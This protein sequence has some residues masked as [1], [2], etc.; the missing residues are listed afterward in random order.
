VIEMLDVGGTGTIYSV[1][2]AHLAVSP[3]YQ[4][5]LPYSVA[6]V[7][8]DEGPRVLGR[9]VGPGV[10]G[11]RVRPVFDDHPGWTE[12]R[13]GV[14][15]HAVAPP[16]E[17]V[18]N[19]AARSLATSPGG[20]RQAALVGVG[21]TPLSR[22]SGRSVLSLASEAVRAAL[23]DAGLHRRDVD[24]MAS[25]MVNDDSVPCLGVA[26][27]LGLGPMR[28]VLDV[29]M[30]GQAPCHLVWQAAQAV[31]RGDAE[32]IVVYRA[33]NGRS[34]QRVGSMHFAG[35][36]GQYR[37]PIGYGA[38]MMYVGMW[39][40][41]FLYETGQRAE[42]LGAVAVSQRW[43]AE[44]NERAVRRAPLD[45]EDY[46]AQPY[47]VDPF[48][49]AD[50][51]VE[52]DGACAVVVTS[53]DRARD[54]PHP[55][56]VVASGA[57]AAG[58]HPGFD[59]GDHLGWQDYSRNFT[60]WLRGELFGR[61]GIVPGDV[62]FAEIYD[63]FTS[64]VL[65]GMEGL[66]LCERGGSGEF[67][68]KGGCA[69]DG[70]LPTNTGGGLLAEGYLHGMNVVAEAVTQMQGRAGALQVPRTEIAVVTSGAIMEGSALILTADR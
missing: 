29:A 37:Y 64:T 41:R 58:P 9:L 7:E 69:I 48:R 60:T 62:Q 67:V 51:T 4:G 40:R 36:A 61:V 57:Y 66:G 39:G 21:Y 34:G 12:L 14:T 50:C 1:V 27:D 35:T 59:I 6:T 33:L 53:L 17:S 25:F 24:G 68:S 70:S 54:L 16:V 45:L 22:D 32:T 44:R 8:L 31:A 18:S 30:G 55:P 28:I 26:S 52:V 2:V 38:Y 11:D 43:Y 49:R 19:P 56:A 23:D 13:F 5:E 10:I 3:G 15:S 42:D 47:V 65:M 20:G 63:C 46:L